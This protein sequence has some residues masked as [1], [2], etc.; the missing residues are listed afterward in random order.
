MATLQ[1]YQYYF[2]ESKSLFFCEF[3]VYSVIHLGEYKFLVVFSIDEEMVVKIKTVVV[4]HGSHC[5]VSIRPE[6]EVKFTLVTS[7]SLQEQNS[8]HIVFPLIVHFVLLENHLV[9]GFVA[10]L[11]GPVS[12]PVL[13]IRRVLD[14]PSLHDRPGIAFL[15]PG[16]GGGDIDGGRQR[17]F[18]VASCRFDHEVVSEEGLVVIHGKSNE[19]SSKM[20]VFEAEL[21]RNRVVFG[22]HVLELRGKSDC[23]LELPQTDMHVVPGVLGK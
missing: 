1:E 7:F 13:P 21:H 9:P 5:P 11:E 2:F 12:G 17:R 10:L 15:V 20:M 23:E 3:C 4:Q 18:L 6:I 22:V 8:P 14:L 19:S 16:A